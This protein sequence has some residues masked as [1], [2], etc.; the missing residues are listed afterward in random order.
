MIT[1]FSSEAAQQFFNHRASDFLSDAA[2]S[3]ILSRIEPIKHELIE[4]VKN[5]SN[6]LAVAK[7]FM[8]GDKKISCFLTITP[9]N[10]LSVNDCPVDGEYH[11]IQLK[12]KAHTVSIDHDLKRVAV[13]KGKIQHVCAIALFPTTEREETYSIVLQNPSSPKYTVSVGGD[14]EDSDYIDED[15]VKGLAIAGVREFAEEIVGMPE[16]PPATLQPMTA[17]ITDRLNGIDALDILVRASEDLTTTDEQPSHHQVLN[18]VNV[19]IRP[20]HSIS[21]AQLSVILNQGVP[22]DEKGRLP[23]AKKPEELPG[24]SFQEGVRIQQTRDLSISNCNGFDTSRY[25]NLY[26]LDLVNCQ[27]KQI[28]SDSCVDT[29]WQ[30][31]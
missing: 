18:S 10:L 26:R 6:P 25:S 30:T 22:P 31:E 14:V 28:S 7:N 1:Q 9:E 3:E 12:S 5:V 24:I 11:R 19:I 17:F 23:C 16:S 8:V 29:H 13:R 21:G 2:R 20:T 27:L 15:L 4:R